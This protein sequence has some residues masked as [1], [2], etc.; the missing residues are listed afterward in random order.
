MAA[1]ERVDS[2]KGRRSSCSP[3]WAAS[4]DS[5][6]RRRSRSAAQAR[7]STSTRSAVAQS[8]TASK[9]SSICRHR[10]GVIGGCL[11]MLV[12]RGRSTLRPGAHR[13]AHCP[14][15]HPAPWRSLPGSSRQ[16]AARRR[17]LSADQNLPDDRA[18]HR[19]RPAKQRAPASKPPPRRAAPSPAGRRAWL[20]YDGARDRPESGASIGRRTRRNALGL[21]FRMTLTEEP[22]VASW[23]SAV[24]WSV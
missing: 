6:S 16:S 17:A 4:R 1:S 7:S 2:R 3:A 24:G 20:H 23:M 13:A 14:P 22:Q 10:S 19:A 15:R 8:A 21:P 18:P 5:T 12:A 11:L 9:F